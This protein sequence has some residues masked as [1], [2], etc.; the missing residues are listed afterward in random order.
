MKLKAVLPV[1]PF[2]QTTEY[3]YGVEPNGGNDL[4]S[5]DL[6]ALVKHPDKTTGLPSTDPT[7]QE[8]FAY[9]RLGQTKKA[10]YDRNGTFHDYLF[11]VVGRPTEDQVSTLGS[12]VD[13]LIRRLTT[14][15]D[16]VG[17]PYLFSSYTAA[18]GGTLLNQGQREFN[19]LGQLT[20]EY[21]CHLGSVSGCLVPG[22]AP[23][24]QYAYSEMSGGNHSR[25]ASLTYPN[26]RVVHYNYTN[27]LHSTISRL[28]VLSAA[29]GNTSTTTDRSRPRRA[30]QHVVPS[31]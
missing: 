1:S 10:H 23:S 29:A 13:G 30:A 8:S 19:G 21:Q 16:T 7:Q 26:G 14:A 28:S 2:E 24:V 31:P 27:G 5:N 18:T 25:R 15:Y 3:V 9:N 12:G 17:R 4:T 20:R 6:L 22:G 11:D